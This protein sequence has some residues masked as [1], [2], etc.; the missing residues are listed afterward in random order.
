M[1]VTTFVVTKQR[2]RLGSEIESARLAFPGGMTQDQLA[3]ATGLSRNSIGHYERGKRAPSYDDL[4]KIANALRADHF[5]LDDNMRIEFGPNGKPP[6]QP[7]H[8]QLTLAFDENG[9]VSVRIES[10][11]NGVI[12]RKMLA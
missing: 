11:R 8:E 12:V 6:Q 3:A 9:G 10:A 5:D 4:R 2:E 7:A 1:A